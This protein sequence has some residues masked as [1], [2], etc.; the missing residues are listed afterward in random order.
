MVAAATVSRWQAIMPELRS[1]PTNVISGFLGVGKT[2]AILHLLKVRPA[3][4]R[5]AVLVNEFGQVGIDGS[6]FQGNQSGREGAEEIFIREVPGGCMCCTNGLPMQ[7]ALNQLIMKARPDR[8]LIEPT[9]LGHPAE[10]LEVISGSHYREVLALRAVITLVDARNIHDSRYFENSTFKQQIEVAD[11]VVASK[12]DLASLD[13]VRALQ[14]YLDSNFSHKGTVRM[15]S[16]GQL[17]LSWLDQP[18]RGLIQVNAAAVHHHGEPEHKVLLQ[19][20]PEGRDFLCFDNSRDAFRSLGWIFGS[21]TVF[22]QEALLILLSGLEHVRFKGVFITSDG[23]FAYNFAG[24]GLSRF[25]VDEASD[26]RMEII[27]EAGTAGLEDLESQL[28]ACRLPD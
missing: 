28:L 7:A 16:E 2:T 9:G 24:D 17:D 11:I 21:A 3:G 23:I 26:S 5:W 8:L 4:E 12:A 22:D 1:I 18:H 15:I 25:E 13:D 20:T 27:C 14:Q 10:I 6:L 19:P